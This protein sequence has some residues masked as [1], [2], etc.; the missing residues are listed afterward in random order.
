MVYIFGPNNDGDT[1]DKVTGTFWPQGAAFV[2]VAPRDA[3]NVPATCP[4]P[5]FPANYL[6]LLDMWSGQITPV[7]LHGPRL[8]PQGDDL[9]RGLSGLSGLTAVRRPRQLPR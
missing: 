9:R 3:N 6:G 7:T 5:G 8:E 4:G 1:I 2:A